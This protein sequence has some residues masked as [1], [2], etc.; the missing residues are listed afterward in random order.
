MGVSHEDVWAP[1]RQRYRLDINVNVSGSSDYTYMTGESFQTYRT[2]T[3]DLISRDL[4]METIGPAGDVNSVGLRYAVFGLYLP[5]E[6]I[7]R[8]IPETL[9]L[10][11]RTVKPDWSEGR[12]WLYAAMDGLPGGE[13]VETYVDGDYV[14]FRYEDPRA[15]SHRS[16]VFNIS[17]RSA[18]TAENARMCEDYTRRQGTRPD[19]P[20]RLSQSVGPSP[21]PLATIAQPT[22]APAP[23]PAAAAL[24][25]SKANIGPGTYEVG[26]DIRHGVYAGLAGT[27]VSSSRYRGRLICASGDVSEIL[28]D[29]NATGQFY[30][31]IQPD[32]RNFEFD[33]EI[34]LLDKWPIP[35]VPLSE[36]EPGMYQAGR[37]IAPRTYRGLAETDATDSCYRA[38]LSGLSGVLEHLIANDTA[39]GSYFVTVASSDAA[40]VT[41]CNLSLTR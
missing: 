10:P 14:R 29:R 26:S 3:G 35:D 37:D 15:Y 19:A 40:L 6:E 12:A 16:F 7:E 32:D 33:C 13:C 30:V 2:D 36:L 34:T 39:I 8:I 41:D 31:E 28:A 5:R 9:Y 22:M 1:F 24:P 38:R 27:E 23:A 4:W 18:A 17:L 21:P 25:N 20:F 11:L